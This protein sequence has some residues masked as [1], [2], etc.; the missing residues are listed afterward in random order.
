MSA[1]AIVSTILSLLGA[2]L[3]AVLE[4]I[5]DGAKAREKKYV[6]DK[7]DAGL[8]DLAGAVQAADVDAVRL[9]WARHDAMLDSTGHATGIRYRGQ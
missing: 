6:G 3:P 1:L 4:W 8:R 9:A 2:A 5:D 7:T